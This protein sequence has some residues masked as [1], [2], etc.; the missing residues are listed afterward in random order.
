MTHP[1]FTLVRRT[2]IVSLH[3]TF[4][5]YRHNKTGARHIHLA[6]EDSNN[7]F[8]VT[9]LTV[10]EDSTGVAHILEH[11]TLCGSERYP[12]RDPFFMMT[13][14]SLNTFMNAFTGSDWTAYPFASQSNKD[15]DNLLQ[16][17]LDAVFFPLLEPLDF[18]Q[19]GHRLEFEKVDDVN[20]PLVYK[21]VVYNEMK[22]AMSSPVQRLVIALNKYL[23]PTTTYHYNSG[24][25]PSDIPNLTHA[26]LKAFHASHYHPS[27]AA[28]FTYGDLSAERHQGF[29]ETCALSRFESL[30]THLSVANEQRFTAP[31]AITL[32]Y[33]IG[34][35]EETED[36]THIL[37]AWLLNNSTDVRE[38]L[39][40]DLLAGVL[41]DNSASPLRHALETTDLGLS[42]SALCGFDENA[43]ESCFV[44][45]LEGS[46]PEEAEAVEALIFDV[47]NEVAEHGVDASLV[48]S[49]LHQIELAQREVSG[50]GMPYG[51]QL[52]LQ[53]VSPLL[54]GG[55]PIAFL[56]IDEA[57]NA[58][59]EDCKNP[60]FIPQLTRRLL[61]DNPHRIR[62]VMQPDSTLATQELSA[63]I[64]RLATIKAQLTETA[65][66]QLI[67]QAKILKTKQENSS[68]PDIL[69]KVTLADV[70][71]DLFIPEGTQR[72]IANI[73]TTWYTRSTN[74]MVYMSVAID[75]PALSSELLEYVPLFCDCLSEV[76]CGERGYREN[77]AWQALI[78]GGLGTRLKICSSVDDPQIVRSTFVLSTKSLIRNQQATAQLL[79][80]TLS[81]VRFDE[82]GRLR[83]LIEQ[84]RSDQDNGITERGHEYVSAVANS[85]ISPTAAIA[86]RWYGLEGLLAIRALDDSLTDSTALKALG[87]KLTQIRDAFLTAPRQLLVVCE[88]EQQVHLAEI[89]ET[90]WQTVPAVKLNNPLFQPAPVK[91]LI[92]QAWA[93]STTVNFCAKAYPVT[94]ANHRDTP[95]LIVLGDFL[96]N[97]YIHRA[98]REQ[99]GAY[100][101]T[102]VYDGEKGVFR[103]LSYRDPRLSESLHDFDRALDWLQQ[104]KH[105]AR[106]LEEAI[107]GVI[108][109]I[110]RPG[111]PAGEAVNAFMAGLHGRI[112][113]QRRALRQR[114]LE[115]TIDDL[116]RVAM[117]YLQ[118]ERASVAVLGESK[119]LDT[120][121]GTWERRTV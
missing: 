121:E 102:A 92:R 51:L 16:V 110:D 36:K 53:C 107:L 48:E 41:L 22:G 80:D 95:A 78:C 96:R 70:P 26:Q 50:D 66:Q 11:T 34:E 30:D 19:E 105:D 68:D 120:L 12:V 119:I 42:P 65:K 94:A 81:K 28:F 13:R 47:L 8:M 33:P 18:A 2:P 91:R 7:V 43:K 99:G 118:A 113:E 75:L 73:P 84:I 109:R 17:Y 60:E 76:G 32:N 90:C 69:P 27:N 9:F 86:N 52:L 77:V 62:L 83:E 39:N 61:L 108:G 35:Q 44:C 6:A 100:G 116:Q 37:L 38:N 3:L 5:E 74:G 49:V 20:S 87:Q 46:N 10:P 71:A 106:V 82:L 40:A 89:L 29:F 58:L 21:G 63:E 101:G 79:C 31:Q 15:F 72:A 59:R 56:E 4:E 55:D 64:A 14:R 24:G 104:S 117:T 114:I 23:Y 1:A 115:V 54:H 112:P 111:S 97:G 57:L 88:P 25:E 67:E 93:I 45:G 98:I 85:G 103:F